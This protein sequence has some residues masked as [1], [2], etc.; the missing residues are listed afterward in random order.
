[1]NTEV[2]ECITPLL[3]ILAA[4]GCSLLPGYQVT[5][6]SVPAGTVDVTEEGLYLR[7]RCR[8]KAPKGRIYRLFACCNDWSYDLGILI[9]DG[10]F[11]VTDKKL[12]KKTFPLCDFRFMM[13]EKLENP[14][15]IE[16]INPDKP[17]NLLRYLHRAHLEIKG[18]E[19]YI[20]V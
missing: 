6:S 5:L 4:R 7:F 15:N 10:E 11:F 8:C 20:V 2:R 13:L 17:C 18:E 1:M 19:Y 16:M 3:H 9:P 14:N 12:P